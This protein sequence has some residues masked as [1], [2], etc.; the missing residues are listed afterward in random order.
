MFLIIY[1]IMCI[2]LFAFFTE[3]EYAWI[4]VIVLMFGSAWNYFVCKKERPYYNET[5]TLLWN[6]T[7]G[8]YLWV[9][10]VLF[11]CMLL[12]DTSFSGG[13][14]LIALGM[15]LSLAIEYYFPHPKHTIISKHLEECDSGAECEDYLRYLAQVVYGRHEKDN[16]I[17][18]EN[19]FIRNIAGSIRE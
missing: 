12:K 10:G 13:V 6:M 16:S 8:I 19:Y 3:I 1:K 7:N 17:N 11:I 15:P 18:L 2:V 14:Q 5:I 9:N 4:L